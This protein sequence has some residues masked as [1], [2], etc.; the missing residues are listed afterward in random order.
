MCLIGKMKIGMI[1]TEMK[2][3][4]FWQKAK[5]VVYSDRAKPT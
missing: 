5:M 2:H 4:T 3:Q 1:K